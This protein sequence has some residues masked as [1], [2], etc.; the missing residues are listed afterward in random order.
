MSNATQ[1]LVGAKKSDFVV[2]EDAV[3]ER[4]RV[5]PHDAVV[6]P[7][8]SDAIHLDGH[9]ARGDIVEYLHFDDADGVFRH[10]LR[11][12]IEPTLNNVKEMRLDQGSSVGRGKSGEW[13]HAARV[14]KVVILQWL[15][16][17]GLA[18]SDFKGKLV[19]EF[20]NDSDNGAFRLWPGRV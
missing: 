3:F 1:V 13:M 16:N 20:L 19:R 11:Q 12:D 9:S 2:P 7:T 18:W 5:L 17:R 15:H 8:S 6:A 14:D 4:A 10:E